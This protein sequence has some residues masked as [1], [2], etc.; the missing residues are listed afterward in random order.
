MCYNTGMLLLTCFCLHIVSNFKQIS[1]L[2]FYIWKLLT[3]RLWFRTCKRPW[4]LAPEKILNYNAAIL[5]TITANRF[6]F[7]KSWMEELKCF[8]AVTCDSDYTNYSVS[9]NQVKPKV[10]PRVWIHKHEFEVNAVFIYSCS[11]FKQT[12][13]SGK[14]WNGDWEG[15]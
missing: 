3:V 7:S 1:F 13:F 2:S 9:S 14:I 10:G 5:L 4:E 8:A 12:D 11:V 15:G 6:T